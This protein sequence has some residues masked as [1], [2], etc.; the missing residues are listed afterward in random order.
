MNMNNNTCTK[1]KVNKTISIAE[2]MVKVM[3]K[4]I[5][6]VKVGYSKCL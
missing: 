3:Y 4:K 1:N 2:Q 5:W 6:S